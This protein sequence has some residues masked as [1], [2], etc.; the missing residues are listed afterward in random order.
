MSANGVVYTSTYGTYGLYGFKKQP[1]FHTDSL[2]L[3]TLQHNTKRVTIKQNE[4]D[5]N[6]AMFI[7]HKRRNHKIIK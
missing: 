2:R 6:A 1:R 5:K 4:Q 3:S 7:F